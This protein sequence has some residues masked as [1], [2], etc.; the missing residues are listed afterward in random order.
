MAGR[1]TLTITAGM[2]QGKTPFV[3]EQ[4]DTLLVGRMEDCGVCIPDDTQV[5]RHHFIMEVNPPD[6][7]IRDLG[8]RNGTYVNEVKY[9]GRE[10][11]ETPAQGAEKQFPQLDLHDGDEVRV[12]KTIFKVKIEQAAG[13]VAQPIVR[14]QRCRRDV[15]SET[16]AAQVGA[17]YICLKCRTEVNQDPLA[18]LAGMIRKEAELSVNIDIPGYIIVSKLGEGGMGAVYMVEHAADH[19]KAALK[20]MLSK[21]AVDRLAREKF[22]REIAVTRS[23]SHKNIV[24]LI[25]NGADGSIFYFLL[26]YCDGGSIYDL[27]KKRGGVL[28]V[29]EAVPIMLQSIEGLA[30]AHTQHVV[31]RDLKPQNIL[32]HRG[33]SANKRWIAKIADMGLAKN[34]D[35]AGFSGMTVTGSMAGTFVF[36]PRE[37][38]TDFKRFKP[39]SDVWSMAAT[40]YNMLTGDFPRDRKPRQD[41]LDMVLQNEII[42]I[43]KRNPSIPVPL[44]EVIDK[45]LNPDINRRYRDAGE[46]LKAFTRAVEK[47]K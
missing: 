10:R 24:Q 8:S 47:M 37:Q 40:C 1:I 17:S 23:L 21:I 28:S 14:C 7:R 6:I 5:S 45:S 20:V 32:L 29:E 34:F 26:E 36:M 41:P 30:Y 12:G 25:D 16:G 15:T 39:V 3:F 27:M 38:V 31:H 13:D 35:Q 11:H 9:G 19:K 46:M 18:S 4:H 22:L 33:L 42:P 43:R 2:Q 44:A